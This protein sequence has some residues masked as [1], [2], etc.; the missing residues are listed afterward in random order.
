MSDS[1]LGGRTP[2]SAVGWESVVMRLPSFTF[3]LAIA[4]SLLE[5]ACGGSELPG[6]GGGRGGTGGSGGLGVVAPACDDSLRVLVSHAERPTAIAVSDTHVFWSSKGAHLVTSATLAGAPSGG[7]LEPSLGFTEPPREIGIAGDALFLDGIS[8]IPL[9]H[10]AATGAEASLFEPA[11]A[12]A[13]DRVHVAF[14]GNDG[15]V[16]VTVDNVI[17]RL[18]QGH[19]VDL[20]ALGGDRVVFVDIGIVDPGQPTWREIWEAPIA[21]GGATHLVGDA[22]SGPAM[23][24]AL[25]ANATEAFFVDPAGLHAVAK[26]SGATRLLSA[27]LGGVLDGTFIGASLA[28]DEAKGHLL[29]SRV[30][31]GQGGAADQLVWDLFRV[32]LATGALEHRATDKTPQASPAA[33]ARLTRDASCVYFGDAGTNGAIRTISR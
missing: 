1:P 9:D 19:R 26:G 15:S 30:E 16:S 23:I 10:G 13:T 18:A 6:G 14:G 32:D 8:V 17:R 12:L 20:V 22:A 28:V 33:P 24:F 25:A 3:L 4:A 27:D 2:I 31:K 29:T 5:S 7:A 21:G 11:S